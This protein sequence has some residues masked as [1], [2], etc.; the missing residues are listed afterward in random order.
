MELLGGGL[1]WVK[2][3]AVYEDVWTETRAM[4]GDQRQAFKLCGPVRVMQL[5][6][7]YLTIVGKAGF[8]RDGTEFGN[9]VGRGE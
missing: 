8:F 7:E 2:S 5:G 3:L 1:G 9:E 4:H 6:V